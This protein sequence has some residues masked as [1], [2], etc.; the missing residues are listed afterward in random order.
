MKCA[1]IL[2][3]TCSYYCCLAS[4]RTSPIHYT[5]PLKLFGR[6][7]PFPP[8]RYTATIATTTSD[9]YPLTL[10]LRVPL[11]LFTPCYHRA[12]IHIQ[13]RFHHYLNWDQQFYIWL[14][15]TSKYFLRPQGMRHKGSTEDGPFASKGA[16]LKASLSKLC[17]FSFLLSP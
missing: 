16:L 9:R 4:P 6:G 11:R 13:P 12:R 17:L 14:P 5:Y 7:W 8:R 1:R 2:S 10:L 3:S 15:I